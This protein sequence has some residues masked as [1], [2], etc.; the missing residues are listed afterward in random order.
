MAGDVYKLVDLTG[1]SEKSISDAIEVA[2]DRASSSLRRLGWFEVTDIR[3]Q[4][5]DGKVKRYQV[6]LKVGF[7]LD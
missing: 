6:S 5:A 4:I 1:A 2:V 7:T 3:G